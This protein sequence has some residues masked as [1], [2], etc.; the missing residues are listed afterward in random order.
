MSSELFWADQEAGRVI[1][2]RGDK[3]SYVCAAGITP[4]GPKHIGNFR[5]I[6]TVDLIVRALKERGKSIRF[7]YSW[8]SYDRFRK[9]PAEV[10]EGK[11]SLMKEEIGKPVCDVIDPWGC[12]ESWAEHWMTRLEQEVA[13]TGIKPEYLRQHELYRDCVYADGIKKALNNID[14]VKSLLNK[15]R[16]K[17][18]SENWQP[19]FLYCEKCLKDSTRITDYDGD[20]GLTYECD[21]GYSDTID[22]RKKGLV[23][24]KWR[25]DWPMRWAYYGVDFEPAGK[26]HM[27]E[28]SSR[29]TGVEIVK[30]VFG[31]QPPYGFMYGLIG[32]KGGA[33]KMS[34]SKGNVIFVSDALEVY[35]PE[36]LRYLFVGNRPTADFT[37]SFDED[38]LKIY[39]DFYR[40]EAAYY[41]R[42]EGLSDKRLVNLK[43]IYELSNLDPPSSMPL[44]LSFRTAALI[45][46]TADKKKWLDRVRK[47]EEVSEGDE[48]RVK[49]LLDRAAKWVED[50]APEKYRLVV[51]T[52]VTELKIESRVKNAL[53][54]LGDYLLK[55]KPGLESLNKK[56]F[57][58]AKS[59]GVKK[60]FK[61]AYQV[62]LS[63]SQGPKLAPF[64]ISAGRKK[65][66]RLLISV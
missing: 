30:E 15:Y 18:L 12:H 51:N 43:R 2:E 11:R 50:Y 24:L 1:S 61:A 52:S 10:P 5:E 29:T 34:A 57:E 8:D 13:Q 23:K 48:P 3:E 17:P 9:V 31:K 32:R 7:I 46:Q 47:L 62:I 25:V 38:V 49:S 4:S 44:Q 65:V 22:F 19:I 33:G 59:V 40:C 20:Y 42:A 63:K 58:L 54:E 26:E 35:L 27:V 41:D 55:K 60:F 21:C 64:I 6:I 39:D 53:R 45:A 56:V 28:G 36:V 14:E 66:G 37:I 16:S